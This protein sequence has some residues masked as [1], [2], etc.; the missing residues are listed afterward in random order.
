MDNK[1]E[2]RT[3]TISY[4]ISISI[5]EELYKKLSDLAEEKGK[6][7]SEV[8]ETA[9]KHARDALW[10]EY[11]EELRKEIRKQKIGL[12]KVGDPLK[13]GPLKYV[14]GLPLRGDEQEKPQSDQENKMKSVKR[15][16]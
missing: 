4:R 6:T 14:L 16:K 13:Y 12:L 15:R 3:V 10:E 9:L 2:K 5:P 7:I 11:R 8:I 1:K